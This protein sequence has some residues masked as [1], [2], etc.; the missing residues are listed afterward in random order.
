VALDASGNAY[1]TGRTASTNFPVAGNPYQGAS[2]GGTDAFVVKLNPSASGAA[3]LVYATYLGGSG[4]DGGNGIVVDASG[5][6]TV[7]GR[8]DSTDFPMGAGIPFQGTNGGGF[9][10]FVARL[11]P[12]G[13]TL[14]YATYLGGTGDDRGFSIARDS[15]N[16][17]YVTGQR[18]FGQL[19]DQQWD[20]DHRRRP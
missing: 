8:T 18:R 15:S 5:T 2:G 19:H 14:L 20:P 7:V 11:D 1:I 6:A 13:S 16:N 10:A 12:A 9:D 17:V 4:N 3:S